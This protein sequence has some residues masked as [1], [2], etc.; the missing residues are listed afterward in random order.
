MNHLI[1]TV[2][3]LYIPNEVEQ[4]TNFALNKV[5]RSLDA[6]L[7]QDADV[8]EI[9][10]DVS[11]LI[12][13]ILDP[14]ECLRLVSNDPSLI[15]AANNSIEKLSPLLHNIN[16]DAQL[17]SALRHQMANSI[18]N[19]EKKA[20]AESFALDFSLFGLDRP[21]TE[22][23]SRLHLEHSAI[24]RAVS[25]SFRRRGSVALDS[26][27]K[28][29]EKRRELAESLG[30]NNFAEMNLQKNVL[31]TPAD[32][33]RL[34]DYCKIHEVMSFDTFK[35]PEG[36][37]RRDWNRLES[38][39]AGL[40]RLCG[41]LFGL[42]FTLVP[43]QKNLIALIV[44]DT[45][46]GG[47]LGLII[48]DM[49][50]AAHKRI[51]PSNFTLFGSKLIGPSTCR[52]L[53]AMYISCNMND[54]NNV[55]FA[56]IQSLFHEFGHALHGIMSKTRY[57]SLS[58]TRCTLDFAEYP[59]ML[60]ERLACNWTVYGFMGAPP[61]I[62]SE[63]EKS[64]EDSDPIGRWKTQQLIAHTDLMMHTHQNPREWLLNRK[65]SDWVGRIEHFNTYGAT[66]YSYILAD[67][68]AS[69]TINAASN[70]PF[71]FRNLRTQLLSKGGTVNA[72]SALKDL[73]NF[74]F[75]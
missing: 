6:A 34:F 40:T 53:P 42:K 23:I 21:D 25:K 27:M 1:T 3:R 26:Y 38:I 61:S 68:L 19:G 51:G 49:Q 64:M 48:L 46:D 69:K 57:Q 71:L 47:P 33:S 75:V 8:V 70:A 36:E 67:V 50:R 13:S 22:E 66:Y 39:V 62:R 24:M 73:I 41:D 74:E 30:F 45:D 72:L 31:R 20:V 12:C 54:R 60:M 17:F 2:K 55:S 10:D 56:E 29:F 7:K 11:N 4:L 44:T 9:L 32:I 35:L 63:L 16:R 14:M 59:S 52:Q 28:L 65:I 5:G 15:E 18:L 37:P 43:F 58:G